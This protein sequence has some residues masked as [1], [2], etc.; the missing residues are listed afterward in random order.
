MG[1]GYWQVSTH[2]DVSVALYDVALKTDRQ[3]WGSVLSADLTFKNAQGAPLANARVDKPLGIVSL[4]HPTAGDCR[5]EEREGGEAWRRCYETH[6]R[7]FITWVRDVRSASVRLDSCAIDAVPAVVEEYKGQWWLWWVPV[8]HIDNSA[9]T[10][11]TVRLWLDSAAC[12]AVE[13]SQ[14][15]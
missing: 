5:K 6:S 14:V 4:I 2:G 3:R 8:P 11:F 1:W 9:S 7:W 15:L 12:R 10:Y 13:Q